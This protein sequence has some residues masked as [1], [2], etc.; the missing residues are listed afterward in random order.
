M[1]TRELFGYQICI[2]VLAF[3]ISG[4]TISFGPEILLSSLGYDNWL[5]YD[6]AAMIEIY[7]LKRPWHIIPLLVTLGSL[8]G[9]VKTLITGKCC[10]LLEGYTL[11]ELFFTNTLIATIFIAPVFI[12]CIIAFVLICG[13]GYALFAGVAF[14]LK[15]MNSRFN[16]ACACKS[17]KPQPTIEEKQSF[18]PAVSKA[19]NTIRISK[20]QQKTK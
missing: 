11:G 7:L 15:T 20:Q 18:T 1:D 14:I 16:T 3:G 19:K 2:L 13:S 6:N 8:F 10:R 9:V 4:S 5:Y 12:E 17:H